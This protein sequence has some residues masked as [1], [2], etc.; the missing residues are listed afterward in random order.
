VVEFL[1]PEWIAA[2]D[3]AARR[4]PRLAACA[5]TTPL[6]VEQRVTMPDGSERAHH[7]VLTD[8]SASVALGRA[9]TPDVVMHTDLE[10]ARDLAL[11]QVNAQHALARGRLRLSGSV[12]ALLARADALRALDDVFGAVRAQT[13][14]STSGAATVASAE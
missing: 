5:T 8:G 13:T 1:S 3:L 4:S 7:L 2:L 12:E 9:A 11:G 14:F 6:V 10:T